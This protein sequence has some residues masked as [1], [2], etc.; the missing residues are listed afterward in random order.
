MASL[1]TPQVKIAILKNP[2]KKQEYQYLN[3]IP[4]SRPWTKGL[5]RNISLDEAIALYIKSKYSN[6]HIVYTSLDNVLKTNDF[7][8]VFAGTEIYSNWGWLYSTQT[9]NYMKKV[10][11]QLKK[12][13]NLHPNI[14]YLHTMGDKCLYTPL[15]A[16]AQVPVTPTYCIPPSQTN[17]LRRTARM[18]G[19]VFIKPSTG[20]EAKN[21]YSYKHGDVE[22]YFDLI[23]SK[24]YNSMII[25]PY[26]NFGTKSN[27]ELKCYF[28]GE[29]LSYAVGATLEGRTTDFYKKIPKAAMTIA[30]RTLKVLHK[31]SDKVIISRIDMYKYNGKY[32]VNEIESGP[33]IAKADLRELKDKWD[34]D[35]LLG[36][37]IIKLSMK[38]T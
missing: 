26:R 17:N 16:K 22:K 4:G 19:N 34:L 3:V 8:L 15:L 11:A 36:E 31:L 23:K 27:P 18:L 7:H 13:K 25:Q 38:Q 6:V 9:E 10:K 35:V 33:A 20:A 30:Q 24:K 1:K 37:R 21:V 14:E 2:F 12:V 32:Y 28:V 29:D 5:S